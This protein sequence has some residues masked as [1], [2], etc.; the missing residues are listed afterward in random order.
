M[1]K[2]CKTLSV[3][4]SLISRTVKEFLRIILRYSLL[5][6]RAL[7]ISNVFV[8]SSIFPA[9][10]NSMRSCRQLF[11]GK[12]RE[13]RVEREYT[14]TYQLTKA[15]R[16]GI[17]LLIVYLIRQKQTVVT[18]CLHSISKDIYVQNLKLDIG[19]LIKWAIC[20]LLS[21]GCK[22]IERLFGT[23]YTVILF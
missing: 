2:D 20:L 14:S 16:V 19:L 4:G 22:M 17:I 5:S 1:K 12:G 9:I 3:S 13:G 7:T 15:F 21:W 23:F 18:T 10:F 11:T 6:E 8:S